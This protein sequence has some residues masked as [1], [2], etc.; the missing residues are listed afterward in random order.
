[1]TEFVHTFLTFKNIIMKKILFVLCLGLVSVGYGQCVEGDCENGKGTYTWADGRKYSGEWKDYMKHGQG[2]FTYASG[3]KYV[4]EWEN[5]KYHG[6]GTYTFSDGSIYSGEW[7]DGKKH[8]QGTYTWPNG[9]KYVGGWKDGLRY[10]SEEIVETFELRLDSLI[11]GRRG[12]NKF[13]YRINYDKNKITEEAFA[14][15]G[16]KSTPIQKKEL[17]YNTRGLIILECKYTWREELKKYEPNTFMNGSKTEFIYDDEGNNIFQCQYFWSIEKETYLPYDK[18]EF[19]Y[20]DNG[21]QVLRFWYTWNSES[22]KFDVF[23]K[24]EFKYDESGNIIEWK[25]Y[26]L[27]DYKSNSIISR[28]PF[29]LE[30][31][32]I[33]T[34]SEL[35]DRQYYQLYEWN[36]KLK[37]MKLNRKG[38][39]RYSFIENKEFSSLNH[40]WA[41]GAIKNKLEKKRVTYFPTFLNM[42][43]NNISNSRVFGKLDSRKN[44]FYPSSEYKYD[45][46][47]IC[48]LHNRFS[49]NKVTKA[50]Y[51]SN[52]RVREIVVDDKKNLIYHYTDSDYD[53]DLHKWKIDKEWVEYYSKVE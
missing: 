5:E 20:D 18:E 16:D 27:D 29:F 24:E 41:Y 6:Q 7:K 28:N 45:R 49:V 14:I 10:S 31:K 19:K 9:E 13:I 22:Q 17:I 4:G 15:V 39:I 11:G 30:T 35:K 36:N 8:G 46:Y 51:K 25:L 2:T 47:G 43:D 44:T 52:T 21:N 1:M 23:D 40:A 26:I 32:Y 50:N 33:L 42:S 48:I 38:Q 34:Y 37:R 53:L 3:D 12:E